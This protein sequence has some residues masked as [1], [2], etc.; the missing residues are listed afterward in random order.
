M[1]KEINGTWKTSWINHGALKRSSI[2]LDLSNLSIYKLT[3]PFYQG[4]DFD[5]N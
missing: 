3:M 1:W 2:S 5:L 4:V